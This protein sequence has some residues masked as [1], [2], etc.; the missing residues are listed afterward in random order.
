MSFPPLECTLLAHPNPPTLSI[1]SVRFDLTPNMTLSENSLAKDIASVHV[2]V[3]VIYSRPS[4]IVGR[5]SVSHCTYRHHT[6]CRYFSRHF[7]VV[8][9]E[10]Q[11]PVQSGHQPA[12]PVQSLHEDRS[13][14]QHDLMDT[15]VQEQLKGIFLGKNSCDA[16]KDALAVVKDAHPH[17]TVVSKE[18]V[19]K[20]LLENAAKPLSRGQLR[21]V[22][23]REVVLF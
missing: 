18:T 8:P 7:V 19:G 23:C 6:I 21:I 10:D 17:H 1:E 15:F 4:F 16:A 9:R 22:L 12:Q 14:S 20:P 5:G 2:C 3:F 13:S 11:K